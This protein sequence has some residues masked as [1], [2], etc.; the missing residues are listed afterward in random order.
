MGIELSSEEL[1]TYMTNT[2]RIILCVTRPNRAPLA[3]PM[4]FGWSDDTII[5]RTLLA[6]KKVGYIRENPHI[7][8]LVE[9]G[10]EYFSLKAALL[11]GT[12]EVIDDQT[13]AR[14]LEKLIYSSKPI[15]DN[16]YPKVLPPHL[17]AFYQ[18]PLA[19]LRMKPTSITSWDFAKVR[20]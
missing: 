5:M 9:T 4:W 13:E 10:E 11:M 14:E 19:I 7:S 2:P 20:R 12:C 3:L 8:C 1:N 17:E 6:S 18:Q 16:L 15:Y